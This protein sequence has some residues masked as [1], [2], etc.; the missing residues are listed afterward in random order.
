[1]QG[2]SIGFNLFFLLVLD[3]K[4]VVVCSQ[5]EKAGRVFVC[6]VE[7]GSTETEGSTGARTSCCELKPL[8]IYCGSS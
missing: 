5:G 1:M 6:F 7:Q 8:S 3:S 2:Q 4:V